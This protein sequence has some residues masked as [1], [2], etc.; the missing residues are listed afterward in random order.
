M[1]EKDSIWYWLISKVIFVTTSLTLFSACTSSKEVLYLQDI[2][3]YKEEKLLEEHEAVIQKDDLL[4]IVV[5]SRNPELALPF[6]KPLLTYQLGATDI[7][8]IGIQ[9]TLGYLVDSN[10]DIDFPILGKVH[11]KGLTRR[12]LEILLKEQIIAG[13]YIKEPILT[14]Q[15]LNFRISVMGEV[16]SPGDYT[17]SSERITLLEA[18][19]LAGDLTIYGKRNRVAVIREEDGKRTFLY[20]DLR[21]S[22]LFK[23]PYYYLRQNDVV[24]VE[25]NKARIGESEINQNNSVGVWLS[26]VS[27][28]ASI[29]SIIIN[30]RN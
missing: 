7:G 10:G 16:R 20:H 25:P 3:R 22:N 19:S 17:I 12:G 21:S 15:F 6:N 27:L 4:A 14:V 30:A 29:I 28:I 1:L 26:S 23:S 11:V 8:G 24:Y 9:R 2:D 18:L 13:D 5:S